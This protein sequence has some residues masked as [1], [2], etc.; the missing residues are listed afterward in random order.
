[1]LRQ[2]KQLLG[3]EGA[4]VKVERLR[5]AADAQV[6]IHLVHREGSIVSAHDSL[7]RYKFGRRQF[8]NDG[9]VRIGKICTGL[10]AAL[11]IDLHV[12]R[13][14]R[15]DRP[16]LARRDPAELA[17]VP[18]KMRLI[19]VTVLAREIR[20]RELTAARDAFDDAAQAIDAAVELRRESDRIGEE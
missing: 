1:R 2:P 17:E 20:P 9:R 10:T 14:A 12:Q 3:T 15:R 5:G 8:L 13:R 16:I 4:L 19:V 18:R 7:L 11:A 6:G